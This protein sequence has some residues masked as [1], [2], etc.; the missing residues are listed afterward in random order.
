MAVNIPQDALAELDGA[1]AEWYKVRAT[2]N[3]AWAEWDTAL[4]E[5]DR[6]WAEWDKALAEWNAKWHKKLCHPNCAWT[7]QEPNIFAK[8]KSLARLL[9]GG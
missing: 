8:G 6:A 3:K 2:W 9:E 4:A 7:P 1:R 5:R